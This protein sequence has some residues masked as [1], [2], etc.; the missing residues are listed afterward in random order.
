MHACSFNKFLCRRVVALIFMLVVFVP[1]AVFAHTAEP[2]GAA[3]EI[4]AASA[5]IN[6]TAAENDGVAAVGQGGDMHY[7]L[8]LK[9]DLSLTIAAVFASAYGGYRYANMEVPAADEVY[10]QSR[11]LPWD[12]PFAARYSES[13]DR[14]SKWAAVL[15]ATPLVV[16]G[17]SWYRGDACAYDFG[18]YSLMFVQALALQSGVN[19]FVRS[20]ELWPRPYMYGTD[21]EAFDK[22]REAEGEAYGSFFSGHASA[23]FTVA[24]FT[25]EWFSEVYPNSPYKGVVWASALSTAGLV[26]VLRI[27]AGKHYPTDV[28]VGALV[29][30]GISLSVIQLHKKSGDKVSLYAGLNSLGFVARF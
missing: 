10:T 28:V 21:G 2:G 20:L 24:V 30:T 9:T 19:L 3:A 25:G 22:A 15:G 29:G 26:G 16:G 11:L 5:E 13:A 7:A 17:I 14:V 18:A 23:A 4:G 6:G 12:K 27:A 8:S 1:F